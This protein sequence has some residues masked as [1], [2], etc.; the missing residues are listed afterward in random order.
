MRVDCY[1]ACE[2]PISSIQYGD[3]FYYNS[4]LY[5]KVNTD[6]KSSLNDATICWAVTL[7]DGM[8]TPFGEDTSVI[9]ADTKVVVNTKDTF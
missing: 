1:N 4:E 7:G 3:T 6:L 9:L 2:C 8:L 5:M